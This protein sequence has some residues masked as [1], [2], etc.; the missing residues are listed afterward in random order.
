[1]VP[2]AVTPGT[3]LYHGTRS[4]VGPPAGPDWVSFDPEHSSIFGTRLY[5]WV[6]KS[7]LKVLYLDGSRSANVLPP[8]LSRITVR[9]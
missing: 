1:M 5:T 4:T 3:L 8:S 7:P 2:G 6:V 9:S